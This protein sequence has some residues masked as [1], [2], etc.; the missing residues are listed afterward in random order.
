M[1]TRAKGSRAGQPPAG[2]PGTVPAGADPAYP[3]GAAKEA[4]LR[5]FWSTLVLVA[6]LAAAPARAQPGWPAEAGQEGNPSFNLVDRGR[7]PIVELYATPADTDRW[8][9]DRLRRSVLLPGQVFPVRLPAGTCLY[10]LR[11]VYADGRPEERRGLDTCRVDALAF[12]QSAADQ[13]FPG[14]TEVTSLFLSPS[15]DQCW[16]LDRLGD[17]SV[18]AGGTRVIRLPPGTCAYDV[19]VVF[20]TGRAM[21]RRGLNLCAV[22]DLLV[23]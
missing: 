2:A 22:T 19:R 10:D 20:A 17:E 15:A 16:G 1:R 6:L 8:G 12:P 18:P 23:P 14:R 13:P 3:A 11:V 9:R 5:A 21:E 4:R 7:L